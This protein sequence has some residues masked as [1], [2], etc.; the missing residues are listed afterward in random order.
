MPGKAT[1]Q[2][3]IQKSKD[4]HGPD[5]FDYSRCHYVNNSTIV[6]LI[7]NLGHG[8][9]DI[10]P[11]NHTTKKMVGCPYCAGR[12]TTT[13]HFIMKSREVHGNRYNYDKVNFT[14]AKDYVTITCLVDGHGDFPQRAENHYNGKNGCPECGVLR[15]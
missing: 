9:F 4:A 15:P 5:K 10:T 1:L 2:D 11:Q 12:V 8:P 14:G 3:F 13:E 6:T 7:C